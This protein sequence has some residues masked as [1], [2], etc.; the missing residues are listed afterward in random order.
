MILAVLI[1]GDGHPV[2]SEMWPG[3]T[4]D[5]TTLVP[6]IER[7]RRRSAIGRVCI[8]ADRGMISA[9][10]AVELAA[11]RLLYILGARESSVAITSRPSRMRPT[12]RRSSPG[13]SRRSRKETRR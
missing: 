3:N 7:L 12:G 2:C 6:V 11:R 1:D 5:M 9:E 13:W 10:T 8:I 4:A